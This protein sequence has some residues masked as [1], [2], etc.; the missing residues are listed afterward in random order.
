MNSS[1]P[2]HILAEWTGR[3]PVS[4]RDRIRAFARC[5]NESLR[6]PAFLRHYRQLGV[7]RFFIVD[8][9][10]SDG[11][12][13]YLAA[14]ADVRLFRTTNRYSEASGGTGWLNALLARFGVGYWCVTVDVDELLVYPASE[15]ASL[16][17]LTAYLD[18]QGAGAFACMLL[19]LYPA[20]PLQKCAYAVGGDLL[21]ASP[22][23]DAG[24]YEI[25]PFDA[26]PA[27]HIRGGVRQR[28]FYPEFKRR[29]LAARLYEAL[30]QSLAHR[31]P[32]L[33]DLPWVRAHR[34][35]TPPLL[36]KVPL[37]RWDET[38]RYVK[39]NHRVTPKTVA[40]ETG[41]LLHFKFL[42][43]FHTR[44]VHE[45]NRREYSGGAFDY[46][47][48]ARRLDEHPDLSLIYE[49]SVRFEGSSQLVRLGLMRD[50]DAWRDQRATGTT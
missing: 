21:A 22:Y 15:H 45:A 29:R 43:D 41:V 11:S 37:V 5:R 1:P 50:T 12:A 23:F 4:S 3:E 47:R 10:S 24:P 25:L 6:L 48:Y 49:G 46:R 30:F 19:D 44:A 31:A 40:A 32:R 7:D 20:G 17:S 13:E 16:R 26:C 39:S 9:D 8:N 2:A 36:T 38:T 14:Q 42:Q 27:L 28:V 18:R 35:P 33:H 34:P